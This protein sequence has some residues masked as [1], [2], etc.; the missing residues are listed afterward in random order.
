MKHENDPEKRL[1]YLTY[2]R[3]YYTN[4]KNKV[5]ELQKAYKSRN[6][7][8]YAA[9]ERKRIAAKLHALP[10]WANL[11][12]IKRIYLEC[13]DGYEV[14]HIYPLK[15]EWVCGLHVENNL[16]YLS[17]KENRSKSNKFCPQWH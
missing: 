15:S 11:N 2:Q 7:Q 5:R 16:Q 10:K 3:E 8:R 14:D 4:N 17:K 9:Y 13:P 1:R 12:V 6:R